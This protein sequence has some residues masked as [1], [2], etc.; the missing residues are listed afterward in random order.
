MK[1]YYRKNHG[2]N[3]TEE[4]FRSYFRNRL[5]ILLQQGGDGKRNRTRAAKRSLGTLF[6]LPSVSAIT[7]LLAVAYRLAIKSDRLAIK[8]E[9]CLGTL[10]Q[11]RVLW[12]E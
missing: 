7:R 4:T 12:V 3:A 2:V 11:T 1:C 9:R 8:S 5:G 10:A 6:R